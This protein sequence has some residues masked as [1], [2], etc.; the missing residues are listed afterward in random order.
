MPVTPANIKYAANLRS[1]VQV[2]IEKGNFDYATFFPNSKTA[3]KNIKPVIEKPTV[4]KLVDEYIDVARR[5]QSLSPST[6]ASYARWSEARIKPKF[7]ER[8]AEEIPTPELRA[9]ISELTGV[10]SVKSIRN[11]VGLLCAVLNRALA[12][13]VIAINPLEPIKLKSV[14]PKQEETKE[15]DDVD[16]LSDEEIAA[17]LGACRSVQERALWQFAI[18]SGLRTGELIA[19]KWRDI[20]E[21]KGV[22]TVKDNI[23][24]AEVG[25]VQ[26]KTKTN[27]RR[28]IPMLPAARQAIEAMRGL[29]QMDAPF[30]FTHPKT[31][32]RWLDDQQMRKG[33][34]IPTLE[35]AGV[36]YRYPYQT[37]HTF[38]SHLLKAGEEELLVA[39]LLGHTTVE[40]VRRSYGKFIKQSGGFGLRGDY[41]K[42]GAD[43]GHLGQI[44]GTENHVKPALKI[45]VPQKKK[46]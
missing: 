39:R 41:S 6:I 2:A 19:L 29:P 7:G 14:L 31:Q 34:W 32:R 42:F 37:R 30:V 13:S 36:R 23:V 4:T 10:M 24:S 46:A 5:S 20:D 1:A 17:I 16:P 33:S 9:W 3:I 40:M 44:R 22:I 35:L 38:A 18:A 8:V 12:D 27:K 15:E 45:V 25:T 21:D 28:I 43:L 26:K 11:C